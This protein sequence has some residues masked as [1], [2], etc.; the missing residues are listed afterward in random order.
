MRLK[1][2]SEL[3]RLLVAVA[4]GTV[5]LE[6]AFFFAQFTTKIAAGVITTLVVGAVIVAGVRKELSGCLAAIYRRAI[7]P[8]KSEMA[9]MAATLA[10][11]AW[12][13][14]AATAPL[15]GSDALQY[16]FTVPLEILRNGFKP[17]F[18]LTNGFLVGQSHLLILAG[19]SL[20]SEK[21]ALALV[22]SV[23]F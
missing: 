21:L 15:V 9:L 22:C 6:I 4:L 1:I 17:D 10:I 2:E 14:L 5:I 16:H 13:G 20:G 7:T 23:A 11:V 3:R 19:L 8:S 18:F 12:E